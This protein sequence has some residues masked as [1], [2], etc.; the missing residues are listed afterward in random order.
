MAR[1][2]GWVWMA[3]QLKP[4]D[5]PQPMKVWRIFTHVGSLYRTGPQA[6][7]WEIPR[8]NLRALTELPDMVR[9]WCAARGGWHAR[10]SRGSLVRAGG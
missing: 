6:R 10:R 7:D 3:H 2:D 5:Y 1:D 9:A 8:E 4:E